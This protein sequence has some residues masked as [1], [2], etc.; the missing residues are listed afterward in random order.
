MMAEHLSE[1]DT[2]MDLLEAFSCF[3][4]GDKGW[5]SG[6][7]LQKWLKEVGDRMSDQ[8]VSSVPVQ[9]VQDQQLNSGMKCSTQ[10]ERFLTGPFTDRNGSFNYRA[11]CETLRVTDV[12][13]E[14]ARANERAIGV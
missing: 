9:T 2:E 14:L 8:E 5:I 10:I 7:E 12:D 3:D 4:E 13:D 6:K 1:M 11:F